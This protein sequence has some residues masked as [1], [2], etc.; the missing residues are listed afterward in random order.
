MN[1]LDHKTLNRDIAALAAADLKPATVRHIA[2][3]IK[4]VLNEAVDQGLLSV[5]RMA[6]R[7]IALPKRATVR[8]YALS[9]A[10]VAAL[11]ARLRTVS[12][13]WS[14]LALFAAY[15]GARAANSRGFERHQLRPANRTDREN[16]ATHRR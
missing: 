2:N 16:G 7:S 9:A 6:K 14:T 3:V 4:D 8:P 12:Q 11:V 5:D 15:T 10:E 13:R 1:P